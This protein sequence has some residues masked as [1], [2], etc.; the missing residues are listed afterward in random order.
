VGRAGVGDVPRRRAKAGSTSRERGGRRDCGTS[1][2]FTQEELK[3][4]FPGELRVTLGIS[5][6]QEVWMSAIR[7]EVCLINGAQVI[8]L[9][10][11]MDPLTVWTH[12]LVT[13]FLASFSCGRVMETDQSAT[14]DDIE[15]MNVHVAL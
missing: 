13:M 1:E 12:F 6:R 8:V 4:V 10:E 15:P 5:S 7:M 2:A 3:T 14:A 11:L 9:T